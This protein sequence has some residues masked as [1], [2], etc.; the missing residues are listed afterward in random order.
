[1]DDSPSHPESDEPSLDIGVDELSW[2][3]L[4]PKICK[5][6]VV[7][8]AA[9]TTVDNDGHNAAQNYRYPTQAAIACRAREA[10]GKADLAFV[11]TGWPRMGKDGSQFVVADFV[12]VHA[13]GPCSPMFSAWMPLGGGRDP[14][15]ALAASLSILRKYVLAGLLNMGWRDPTEDVDAEV[16]QRGRGQQQNRGRPQQ[17]RQQAP[18]PAPHANKT[19]TPADPALFDSARESAKQ[20]LDAGI[21]KENVAVFATGVEGPWPDDPPSS[22]LQAVIVAALAVK[23]AQDAGAE[24]SGNHGELIAYITTKTDLQTPWRNGKITGFGTELD[25]GPAGR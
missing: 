19:P 14:T 25:S 10:L 5:A 15:K 6:L 1:M 9:A 2:A 7:A 8:Q 24:L 22:L 4:H 11:Q 20:L 16:Q 21:H 17:P 3:T 18:K 23:H 13:D 12:L